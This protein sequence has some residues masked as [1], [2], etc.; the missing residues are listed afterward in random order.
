MNAN[1][2]NTASG[3]RLVQI[4][5]IKANGGHLLLQKPGPADQ[6]IKVQKTAANLDV[7][8]FSFLWFFYNVEVCTTENQNPPLCRKSEATFK[9]T[10]MT[11]N[12]DILVD[13]IIHKDTL[14]SWGTRP[15]RGCHC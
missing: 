8:N 2:R 10:G 1:R 4:D 12:G 3:G 11:T 6:Y 14:E 5:A 7:E 9:Y 13:L 15:W